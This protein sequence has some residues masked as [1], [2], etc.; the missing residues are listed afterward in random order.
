MSCLEIKVVFDGHEMFQNCS[1][2]SRLKSIS[3]FEVK[4][5]SCLEIKIDF[6][7]GQEF[8]RTVLLKTRQLEIK[9]KFLSCLE[10]QIVLS[11][12]CFIEIEVDLRSR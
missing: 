10:I 1:L 12:N 7:I 6:Y 3:I 2:K 11:Q 9:V 8:F 4:F 5:L